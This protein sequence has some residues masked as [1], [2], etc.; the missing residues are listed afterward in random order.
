MD[1]AL[2][3]LD[4]A[5]EGKPDFAEAH[6]NKGLTLL[7]CERREDALAS[8]NAALAANPAFIQAHF[9]AVQVLNQLGRHADAAD[10]L[11]KALLVCV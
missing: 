7:L 6:N 9:G 2:A 8:F 5:L 3:A 10:L 1:E 11:Q 4:A